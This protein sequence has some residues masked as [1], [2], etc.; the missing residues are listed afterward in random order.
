MVGFMARASQAAFPPDERD[1]IAAQPDVAQHMVAE[2]VELAARL[3]HDLCLPKR[4]EDL[5][6]PSKRTSAPA[7]SPA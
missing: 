4:V 3:A 6:H 2:R 5:S 1:L 7:P